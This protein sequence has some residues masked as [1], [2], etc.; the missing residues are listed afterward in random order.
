MLGSIIQLFLKTNDQDYNPLLQMVQIVLY[1]VQQ[2]AI[3]KSNS[4]K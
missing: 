1:N 4:N 3:I 2:I